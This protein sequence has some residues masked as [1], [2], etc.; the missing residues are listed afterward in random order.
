[1]K[2]NSND[3]FN[4][5]GLILNPDEEYSFVEKNKNIACL[6]IELGDD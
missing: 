3:I 1:M 4:Q 2:M 5:I 6:E